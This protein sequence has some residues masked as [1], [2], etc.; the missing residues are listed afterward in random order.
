MKILFTLHDEVTPD[1]GGMGVTAGLARVYRELGHDV[2][3]LSFGQLP[4]P[5]PFRAK[6][7]LFP[8]FAAWYMSRTDA[9]VIDAA[10]GDAWVF[11][12][13]RRR[14]RG[15]RR[16]LLVTRSHG[17]VHTADVARRAEA[18]RGGIDLSWKYPL[19]WGGWKLKEVADS[20]RLADL[21][22]FLN[23][24]EHAYAIDR[25][26][27]DPSRARIVDNGIPEDLLGLPL[28]LGA[29][30]DAVRIAHIGSYIPLKGVRYATAALTGVLERHPEISVSFLGPGCPP[31]RVLADFPAAVH[32]RVAVVPRYR[33]EELPA[34]LAAHAVVVSATLKE[35]F[36]LGLLEGMACGLT[37]VTADAAGP[38][39]FIRDGENGLVVPRADARAMAA[40]LERLIGDPP[41]L[42]RLREGA[43]ATA[44]RYS[45]KR[46]APETL[47]LYTEAQERRRR[48]S[49]PA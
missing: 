42:R 40:A 4:R 45:W 8:E 6:A 28:E 14:L 16:P 27:V 49:R 39:Q 24:E 9:D 41:L 2:E 36:G 21:C 34:L 31:E 30:D 32:G 7:L 18:A 19:Y 46:I 17:I 3:S 29:A 25:L 37:A 38:L 1:A 23:V 22:L 33:R 5:L 20:L 35:G 43:H 15:A 48:R 44:Q 26:G 12:H 47:D 11:G 13:L 10:N